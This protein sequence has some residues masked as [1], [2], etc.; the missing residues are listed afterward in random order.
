MKPYYTKKGKYKD[1]RNKVC[2]EYE[3]DGKILNKFLPKPET[4]LNEL[5]EKNTTGKKQ[6]IFT[7]KNKTG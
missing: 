6:P 1:G 7:Y 4:M 5:D 3:E 2:I